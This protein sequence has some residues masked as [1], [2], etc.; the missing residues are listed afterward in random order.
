MLCEDEA[1][2]YLLLSVSMTASDSALVMEFKLDTGACWTV[3]MA[4]N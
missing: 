4:I 1:E 2:D 3:S